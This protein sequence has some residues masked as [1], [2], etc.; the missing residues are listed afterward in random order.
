MTRGETPAAPGLDVMVA[1]AGLAGL[2]AAFGFARA[3]FDVVLSGAGERTGRGRTVALLD[4]SVAFLDS[5]GLWTRLRAE[6][7]P[8]R[9]LRLIDD[10][11]T[12]FPP[13][14]VEFHAAEIGLDAFGWNLENDRMAELLAAEVAGAAGLERVA[15]GVGAYEFGP[16]AVRA[17]LEDGRMISARLAIGADGRHSKARAAA[18]LVARPHAYGQSALTALLA[19]RLPHHDFSTEFHTRGGPFTLVPLPASA[20]APNRSSLV[21][22]MTDKDARRREA[23]D[24]EA[25]AGEI[26]R[27]AQSLLGAVRID[28]ERGIFPMTRQIVPRI[29]ARR[30]ALV[31]DAAH[32][33]PP[34]GAQGLNLGLRDVEAIVASAVEA[35]NTSQ[36]IGGPEA[37]SAYEQA[38]RPDIALRTGMVDGLNRALLTHFAPVDFAR[39]AAL[40]TLSVVGPLRR[41]IMCEGLGPQAPMRRAKSSTP[42]FPPAAATPSRPR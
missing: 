22:V 32:V 42:G 31:G 34:I 17:R 16:D 35:R 3:G 38:R 28:G 29:V 13:S 24:N 36:D 41:F 40:A 33:F 10:T 9:S 12:L 20:A 6:A 5:L 1:G 2:A 30:L 19:H 8:L 37:L 26:E 21:W 27:Q 14:P 4:P 15:S 7:A 11:A 23:L 25:L 39:G 18:G